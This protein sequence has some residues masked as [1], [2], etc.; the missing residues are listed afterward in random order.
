MTKAAVGDLIQYRFIGR[1]GFMGRDTR[2]V[3]LL[4]DDKGYWVEGEHYVPRK[5][6]LTVI[7]MHEENSLEPERAPNFPL[8]ANQ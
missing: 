4:D 8:E 3:E 7:R 5:N 6:V 1:G 2:R